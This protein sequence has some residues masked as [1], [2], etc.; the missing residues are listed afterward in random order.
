MDAER[1]PELRFLKLLVAA[2]AATMIAGILAIVALLALRLPGQPAPLALP[3]GLT[4]PPGARAEALSFGRD[5]VVVLTEDGAALVYDRA[6]GV[7]RNRVVLV[8]DRP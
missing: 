7:L 4:L 2:L 6:T 8:P 5:W 3:E 1:P